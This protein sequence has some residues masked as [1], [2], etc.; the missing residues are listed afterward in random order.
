M[1]RACICGRLAV[2]GDTRR[3]KH[4]RKAWR[5]GHRYKRSYD[6][7]YQDARRRLLA[8]VN[9]A[10]RCGLC[11][12]PARELD[13]WETDHI[14]PASRGGASTF[15]NLQLVH[16]SCNRRRGSQLGAERSAERRRAKRDARHPEP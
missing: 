10:T 14:V 7:S 12:E 11:G 5:G 3:E 13:A 4:R 16:R 6:A 8:T 15:E 2:P 1:R 9:E